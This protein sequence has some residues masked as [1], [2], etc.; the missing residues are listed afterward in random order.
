[1]ETRAKVEKQLAAKKKEEKEEKLRELAQ[2]A[3]DERAGIRTTGGKLVIL[4]VSDR[5]VLLLSV[6]L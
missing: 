5:D 3:R 4:P 1:M 2:R 6:C